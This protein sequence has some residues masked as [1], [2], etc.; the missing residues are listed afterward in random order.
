MLELLLAATLVGAV[1]PPVPCDAECELAAADALLEGAEPRQ[2]VDRLK[3]AR[4]SFPEDRRLLLR[5]ALAYLLEGN[6]FWA[7]RTLVDGAGRWPEDPELAAWLAVV[8]LRQGDPEL[9]AADLDPSLAPADD[10]MRVRWRLLEVARRRLEGDTEGLAEELARIAG[11]DA[12]FLEDRRFWDF[13]RASSD[14]WWSPPVTGT[15][16]LGAGHT[17]NALAGSPTDPGAAGDPSPLGMVELRGRLAPPVGAA[18][19]PTLDLEVLGDLLTDEAA[20]E[21]S[22]LEGGLRLGAAIPDGPRRWSFGYR[23][24]TLWLDQAPSTYAEAHRLEAELE[25]LEGRVLFAGGGHRSY[26]DDRRTRWEGELGVGGPLRP[27]AG[28]PLI[29]GITV[30]VADAESPAYDQLGVSA[31]A[32]ATLPLGPRSL[33]RIALSGAWD[34]YPHSGGAEG[35]AVFGT[36]ERRRDL[37][38]R[39]GVTLWAPPWGQLRPGLE[40]RASRR[41]STADQTPGFDF[42]YDEWRAVLWLRWS[43]SGDPWAPPAVDGAGR[44]PLDWGVEADSGLDD[45]RILDLLRRD[46]ELRRGSSC[47][48]P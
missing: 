10:P 7:E 39:L 42:S 1:P 38:G 2:A 24:E 25:W 47:V 11:A 22:S 32:S 28:R 35:L 45:E 36:S 44:V 13:L 23:A 46:E 27:T 12:I 37:L 17:S 34:D 18:V 9:A 31:A 43:F 21:L 20:R 14:P 41:A 3:A 30:R 19:Q 6:L 16:E 40:V 4:E 33:L 26:R 15:L 48:I 5:L 29:A 8:H